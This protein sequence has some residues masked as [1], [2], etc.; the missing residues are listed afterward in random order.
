VIKIP[1]FKY[2]PKE[3]EKKPRKTYNKLEF[4]LSD[5][6][7]NEEFNLTGDNIV[8]LDIT[9]EINV[10]LNTTQDDNINLENAR[11]I[12]SP[13]HTLYFS[14]PAQAGETATLLIGGEA[15]FDAE[16]YSTFNVGITDRSAA[17]WEILDGESVDSG[18]T[19]THVEI[20]VTD[21]GAYT[22][23]VSTDQQCTI[24][25]QFSQNGTDWYDLTDSAGTSLEYT[26]DNEKKAIGINDV[27]TYVRIVIYNESDSTAT[28]DLDLVAT[29]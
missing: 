13:F 15:Q 14:N 27:T 22:A 23:L 29:V 21:Y 2:G 19:V 12:T 18:A 24:Y 4:D 28:V 25:V 8:P 1:E 20:D 17:T 11:K 16:G 5:A 9:G 7:E 10:K 6:R 3:L 26:V